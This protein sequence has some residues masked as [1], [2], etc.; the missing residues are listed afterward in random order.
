MLKVV[1]I[2]LALALGVTSAA[3]GVAEDCMQSEDHDLTI[4]ACGE[5]LEK[6]KLDDTNKAVV[7]YNRGN[8][9]D[10]K[11]SYPAAIADYDKAIEL[12]PDLRPAYYNRGR[13]LRI[14]GQ[15]ELA[16]ASYNKALELDPK[17]ADS[18][19]NRGRAYLDLGEKDKAIA[20]FRAALAINPAHDKA[21]AHLKELGLEP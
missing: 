12:K 1:S 9:H 14:N 20:D 5:L 10:A 4:K 3:A 18:I 21:L 15:P 7:Y 17:D 8:A 2:C 19:S 11:K 13:A 16:V 6:Y